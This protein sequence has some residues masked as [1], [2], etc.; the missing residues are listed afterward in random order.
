MVS[1]VI[2]LK[3]KAAFVGQCL[4]SVVEAAARAGRVEVIVVDN[5]STDGS[6]ELA[7]AAAPVIR[8]EV[9]T[10][11]SIGGVRN[12]GA[13]LAEGTIL[14]FLDADVVVPEDYFIRIR[15]VF[16]QP[17]IKVAGC[18]VA[19]PTD[20]TWIERT[21]FMLHDRGVSGFRPYI[22][23]GNVA[24]RA[25]FFHA[26]GGFREDL[27]TGEDAE[28]GARVVNAGAENVEVADLQVLH[29][30][31]S[32][33]VW[34]FFKKEV[35]HAQG[36]LATATLKPVDRPLLL[37]LCHA[38][39]VACLVAAALVWRWSLLQSLILMSVVALWIPALSVGYRYVLARSA[40][41]LLSSVVLYEVYYLARLGGLTRSLLPRWLGGRW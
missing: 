6:L 26:L 21:W 17:W 41:P 15:R 38:G 18:H 22:N 40:P 36:M 1:V 11:R 8:T 25:D 28:L 4:L 14:C 30:D 7:R 19:L 31:N 12:Q 27:P 37:T 29:L 35:W 24:F 20:R 13:L 34:G 10:G 16:A 2:P 5:G 23:S 3:N 33:S 9:H 39:T 32:T